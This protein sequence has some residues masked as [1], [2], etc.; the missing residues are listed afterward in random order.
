MET[1]QTQHTPE[2]EFKI[3]APQFL[4][5]VFNNNP[6]LGATLRIPANTLRVYLGQIA[7]R[8]SE[9]ND[10][11]MNAI[12]CQMALYEI[13]DQYSK[14]Y[15]ANLTKKIISEKYTS[16]PE[17]A[18]ERDELKRE[19]EELKARVKELEEEVETLRQFD[20]R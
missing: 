11:K 20:E 18:K 19:N 5:E 4:K 3:H 1:T 8:A 7:E 9:L 12:M 6:T 17:T 14:D 10:P 13:A 15:D 16:A 2:L